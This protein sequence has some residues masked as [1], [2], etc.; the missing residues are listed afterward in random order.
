MTQVMT[1]DG[2]DSARDAIDTFEGARE[3]W[4]EI[5]IDLPKSKAALAELREQLK[6]IEAVVLVNGGA[7]GQPI[8][9]K[10]AEI[11]DA[12][13]RLALKKSPEYEAKLRQIRTLEASL[14]ENDVQMEH[15]AN[16]MK[17]ARLAIE[18]LTSWNYRVA[19]VEA[20]PEFRR[21]GNV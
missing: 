21:N 15:A 4:E 18:Y 10:N 9:G 11:R 8:D 14:A 7:E 3:V 1:R 12:Q 17:G 20:R 13:L 5:A 2:I 6:D 16:A 19:G